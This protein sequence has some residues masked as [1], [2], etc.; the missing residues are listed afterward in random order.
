MS[1]SPKSVGPLAISRNIG[2]TITDP[3]TCRAHSND[4]GEAGFETIEITVQCH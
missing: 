2:T 3:E 1:L 4:F